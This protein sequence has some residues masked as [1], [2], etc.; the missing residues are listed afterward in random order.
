MTE[1]F[2]HTAALLNSFG[3][4]LSHTFRPNRVG[5][6]V[7]LL[8][9][10]QFKFKEINVHFDVDSVELHAVR[11]SKLGY[12]LITIYRKQE[13]P[14]ATFINEFS[15]LMSI[16]TNK[17]LDTVILTGDF[18][19]HFE[20]DNKPSCDLRDELLNYGLLQHVNDGT[21]VFGHILDL[22]FSNPYE[23]FLNPTVERSRAH[24]NNP[25][26]KFDHYPI[27]FD[28]SCITNSSSTDNPSSRQ[29][30]KSFRNIKG[31]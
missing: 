16:I 11:L 1:G 20:E 13:Y 27:F 21:N 29:Y 18:N 5:G 26:I 23:V 2:A 14:L 15:Q 24:S 10:E 8:L 28:V 31:I 30:T 17:H 9:K 12:L 7:A 22:V 3:F 6:G 19:V 4:E 25:Y